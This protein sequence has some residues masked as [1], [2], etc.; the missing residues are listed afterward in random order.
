[1][2][3][4]QTERRINNCFAASKGGIK[5][6]TESFI[7]FLQHPHPTPPSRELKNDNSLNGK[8]NQDRFSTNLTLNWSPAVYLNLIIGNRF[9]LSCTGAVKAIS[10]V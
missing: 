7:P 9:N 1:M 10:A 3:F 6:L 5:N 8:L 4:L 2:K